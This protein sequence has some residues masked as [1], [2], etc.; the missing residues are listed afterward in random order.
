LAENHFVIQHIDQS[1][2][3]LEDGWDCALKPSD[4]IPRTVNLITVCRRR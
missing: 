4:G 1:I 2:A 3:N